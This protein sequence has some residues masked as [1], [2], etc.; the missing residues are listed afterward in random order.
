M[1]AASTRVDNV[2]LGFKATEASV[3]VEP[4]LELRIHNCHSTA[5]GAKS[6][7]NSLKLK[8]RPYR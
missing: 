2:V 3:L 6:C 5:E 4:S 8:H 1:R 7:P